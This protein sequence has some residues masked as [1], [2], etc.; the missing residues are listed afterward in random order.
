MA[1]KGCCVPATFKGSYRHAAPS[2]SDA[3]GRHAEVYTHKTEKI[4]AAD[5]TGWWNRLGSG[6]CGSLHVK[7][8]C[9]GSRFCG[10]VHLCVPVIRRSAICTYARNPPLTLYRCMPCVRWSHKLTLNAYAIYTYA[11]TS[12]YPPTLYRCVTVYCGTCPAGCFIAAACC[13]KTSN[14]YVD[15]CCCWHP[16]CLLPILQLLCVSSRFTFVDSDTAVEIQPVC[17]CKQDVWKKEGVEERRRKGGGQVMP[18]GD[19][20]VETAALA[21]QQSDV[22]KNMIA[23]TFS[24]KRTLPLPP[25]PAA[26]AVHAVATTGAPAGTDMTR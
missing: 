16:P 21:R 6:P 23:H 2:M 11:R 15:C 13:G 10:E 19:A 25:E 9:G 8:A 22:A 18:A 20:T 26:D 5:L 14:T 7:P 24:S 4:A 3:R 1:R 17:C 12:P